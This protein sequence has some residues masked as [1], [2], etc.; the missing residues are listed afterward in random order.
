MTLAEDA[1]VE[2]SSREDASRISAE[3][4]LTIGVVLAEEV[5]SCTIVNSNS[6]VVQVSVTCVL[7]VC[8]VIGGFSFVCFVLTVIF[9]DSTTVEQFSAALFLLLFFF[10]VKSR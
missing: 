9:V 10:F 8:L 7:S 1:G 4:A 2:I 3:V 5:G 6:A